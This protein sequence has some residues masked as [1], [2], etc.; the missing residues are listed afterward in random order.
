MS[1]VDDIIDPQSITRR[2]GVHRR[3]RRIRFQVCIFRHRRVRGSIAARSEI[4][5]RHPDESPATVEHAQHQGRIVAGFRGHL[6][7]PGNE[8]A[9]LYAD[10][11]AVE[12]KKR[13]RRVNMRQFAKRASAS[14]S[15]GRFFDIRL[16][17]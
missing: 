5:V 11:R 6:I 15:W 3:R 2:R 1:D 12:I 14:P 17:P 9:V 7:A 10:G 4:D 8:T 13:A 16:W